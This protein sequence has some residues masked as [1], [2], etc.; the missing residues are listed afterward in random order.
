MK[1]RYTEPEAIAAIEYEMKRMLGGREEPYSAGRKIW[2]IAFTH[3]SISPDVVWPLWL[4]WGA[5]TDWVEVGPEEEEKAKKE[6][7]RASG[8]WLA[9]NRLDA[10]LRRAHLDR[11]VRDEL[12]IERKSTS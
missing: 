12:S 9:L 8:E 6:M 3:A 10:N 1:T 7:L 4:I 5:L 2:E 11:W